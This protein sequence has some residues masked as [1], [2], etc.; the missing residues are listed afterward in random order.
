M[1]Q[2]P[3]NTATATGP[4]SPEN[5]GDAP[6]GEAGFTLIELIIG[7]FILVEMMVVGY[8]L[9]DVSTKT[10]RVQSDLADLQ[11]SQRVANYDLVRNVRMA[12][13][14]GVTGPVA[15]NV[16]DNVDGDTFTVGG[17]EVVDGTDVLTVRGVLSNPIWLPN[18]GA[19][20]TYD[21]GSSTGTLFVDSLN[22]QGIAQDLSLLQS[23]IDDG[24]PVPLVL[25]SLEDPSIYAVVLLSGG[26]IG[27]ADIDNDGS[28]EP[29]EERAT[30]NFDAAAAS[31]NNDA[32]LPLSWGGAFPQ[33]LAQ[34][35][36][37]A[38]VG[39]LEEYRYYVRNDTE[40]V[41]GGSPK[42][43][44]AQF[45]PNTNTLYRG[46]AANGRVDIADNVVDLQI[47]LGLDLNDDGTIAEDDSAPDTD[48]WLF[49]HEDDTDTDQ[50]WGL[51]DA[52][53]A[54]GNATLF[55]VRVS[56]LVRSERR[57][58]TFISDYLPTLENHE[59]DPSPQPADNDQLADRRFRRRVMR[60]VV[61]LRNVS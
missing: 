57:D 5:P 6:H 33:A 17:N 4:A 24:L 27:P 32:Y 26:A 35:A 54:W 50:Y 61:D 13:R 31:T 10:A 40:S 44:R 55:Q 42:L 1:S 29:G 34:G 41:T 38:W 16:T 36:V 28:V 19:G 7:T 49:N 60:S 52:D 56:T 48:E 15:I 59:V 39:I 20:Y 11:Q 37:P 23:V 25:V 43:S 47:A 51:G 58:N 12:G 30:I 18:T 9:F 45:Y 46:D 3:E 14:G 53:G 8:L 22:N 21:Q 2:H